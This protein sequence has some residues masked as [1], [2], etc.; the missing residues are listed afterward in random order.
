LFEDGLDEVFEIDG[1][2]ALIASISAKVDA[3]EDDLLVA[4]FQKAPYL[5]QDL[6]QGAAAFFAAC[7]LRHAKSAFVVASVLDFDVSAGSAEVTGF[8]VTGE[9]FF[10]E[11]FGLDAHHEVREF[12]FVEVSDHMAYARQIG[13]FFFVD[14]AITT[15]DDDVRVRGFSVGLVDHLTGLAPCFVG[16]CTSID[17]ADVGFFGLFG[18]I[19]SKTAEVPTY[20]LNLA[21]VESATQRI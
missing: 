21:F 2:V 17:H 6:R 13:D 4:Q 10:I 5:R 9:R 3:C 8:W 16:D 12:F 15:R 14:L 11:R 7:D 18:E 1:C 20:L 19:V